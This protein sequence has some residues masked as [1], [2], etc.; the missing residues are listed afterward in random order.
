MPATF[1]EHSLLEASTSKPQDCRQSE[2]C[3]T[4]AQFLV[5]I[6]TQI[7]RANPFTLCVENTEALQCS[8]TVRIIYD[9]DVK[10]IRHYMRQ[11]EASSDSTASTVLSLSGLSFSINFI[12]SFISKSANIKQSRCISKTLSRSW[13]SLDLQLQARLRGKLLAQATVSRNPLPLAA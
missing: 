1:S 7:P 11:P 5:D 13:P 9:R 4:T 2:L 12:H 3:L 6:Q 10:Y 8:S